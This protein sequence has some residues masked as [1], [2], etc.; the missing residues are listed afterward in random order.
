MKLSRKLGEI[1]KQLPNP[2]FNHLPEIIERL[3][4]CTNKYP[5]TPEELESWTKEYRGLYTEYYELIA[6]R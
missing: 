5:K 1:W 4:E 2:R 6:V 3:Y